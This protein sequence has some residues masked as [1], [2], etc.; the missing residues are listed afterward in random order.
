MQSLSLCNLDSKLQKSM[1]WP[2]FKKPLVQLDRFKKKQIVVEAGF[3]NGI[4]EQ[5]K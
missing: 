3:A 1:N 5:A 2:V 4:S